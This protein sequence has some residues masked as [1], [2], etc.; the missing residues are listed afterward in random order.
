MMIP[1]FIAGAL[2]A[3]AL[4]KH[5]LLTDKEVS[6]AHTVFGDTVPYS[7]VIVTNLIGVSSRAI[8]VPNAD[9]DILLNIGA[10]YDM[11]LDTYVPSGSTKYTT[12]RALLSEE[13]T[14]ARQIANRPSVN[15]LS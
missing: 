5:R 14:P 3:E 6:F 1:A 10:G 13:L 8:T 11:S 2:A 7:R 15:R 9:S 12:P 4:L